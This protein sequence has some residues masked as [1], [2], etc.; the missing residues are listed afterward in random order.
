MVNHMR[1]TYTQPITI[2]H[3]NTNVLLIIFESFLASLLA[4]LLEIWSFSDPN[5][6]AKSSD[7]RF[8]Y[9]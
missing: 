3:G 7:C 2:N 8:P 4:V 9:G 1:A 5:Y 6:Q